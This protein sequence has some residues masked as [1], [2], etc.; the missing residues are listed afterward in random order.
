MTGEVTLRGKV[1]PVAGIK[2]KVSAAYRAGI[3]NVALPKE[4]QKD[5][6]ELP[7]EIQRR[8]TFHFIE[9]IDEMF[10]LCLLDFTPSTYT[11][12]KIF[13]EEIEKAKRRRKGQNHRRRAVTRK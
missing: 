6:N 1:L 2:E 11:L 8:I 9:K 10:E 13:T 4:N 7:K 12:E 5:I 3:S